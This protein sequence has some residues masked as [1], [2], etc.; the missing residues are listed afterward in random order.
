F[1]PNQSFFIAFQ[2]VF[3]TICILSGENVR[4]HELYS[5]LKKLGVSLND[6]EFQELLQKANVAEDGTVNFNS[7]MFALGKTRLFSE[8]TMLKDAIQAID[9]IEGDQVVVHELPSFMRSMGVRLTDQEFQQA[10]KQIPVDGNGKVFVRDFIEVLTRTL[11]FTELS[12]L[13][14]T[15]KG[16]S[17]I[18]G[19]KVAL[20]NLK[21]TLKNMGICFYPQ[22][23]EELIQTT[24]TDGE[25]NIDI[26]QIV[27]KISKTQR[28]IEI[29]VLNNAIKTFSQFKD[30]QVS[31]SDMQTC[32]R[33]IGVHLTESELEESIMS[34]K[35]SSDGMVDVKE[36][37]SAVKGTGRFQNY[38]AV[39]EVIS[40]LK[41]LKEHT[42]MDSTWGRRRSLNTFRFKLANE[43]IS[44]VLKAAHMTEAGW[45]KFN[46]F[47]RILTRNP[48]FKTSA[49][50]ANGFNV[51]DKLNNGRIGV[52]ELHMIMKSFSINLPSEDLSEALAYCNI[53]DNETV[54]LN[55]FLRGVA[56]TDTFIINPG[57]QLTCMALSKCKDNHLDLQALESTLN[58]MDLPKA[59]ELLQDVMKMAQ[60]DNNGT[61]DFAEFMRIFIVVS[62]LPEATVLKD[63][64]DAMSNI[65]DHQVHVDELPQTLASAGLN[66]T[67]EELQSLSKSLTAAGDGTVGFEDVMI[68]MTGAQSFAEFTALQNAFRVI[69]KAFAEK[70]KKED[71]PGVLE[72]LGIQ[73]SPDELQAV[74]ASASSDGELDGIEVVKILSNVPCISES[75]ALQDATKVVES[76]TD[77][78][79][80]VQELKNTLS[81]VGVHLPNTT[82]NELV[83][84]TT[85]DKNGRIDFKDFLLALGETDDFTELEALQ[86]AITITGAMHGSQQQMHEVQDVL[87][88]LG[89][90]L[91]NE[92]FQQIVDT[93]D[94][95][96][97]GTIKLE[98]F[99][100]ALSKTQR[101]RDSLALHS[102]VETFDRLKD[103]KVDTGELETIV[104][105]LGINLSNLEFQKAL[106][107]TYVDEDRKANFK[108]FLVNVMDNERFC[109][110]SAIYGLYSLVT[111]MNNDKVDISHLKDVLAAIGITLNKEEMK[112]VMKNIMVDDNGKVPLKEFMRLL[113]LTQRFSTAVEMD[114]ALKAMQSIKQDKVN[115]EDLD[116]I[117]RMMGLHLSLNEIQ[118][119][120]KYV[121]QN[122]DGTVSLRDFMFGFTKTQRFSKAKSDR[123]DMVAI[124]DVA[125]HLSNMG[126]CLTQEQLQEA[127]RHVDVDE[128][129]KV[130]MTELL[131]SAIKTWR[132]SQAVID[133][134][135]IHNLDGVLA[136]MGIYL[137]DD[138]V[139][140][141]LKYAAKDEDGRVNLNDFMKGVKSIQLI[142]GAEGQMIDAGDLSSTLV[143]MGINLTEDEMQEALEHVTLDADGKVNLKDVLQSV[144]LMQRPSKHERD[145][146]STQNLDSILTSTGI[147]LT[148]DKLQEALKNTPLDAEGK[149]NLG[150]FMKWVR[151][152]QLHPQSSDEKIELDNLKEEIT[153]EKAPPIMVD[154]WTREKKI[155]ID[156]LDEVLDEMGISLTNKQLY[157]ALK[158][159]PM[160]ADGKVDLEAFKRGASAVLTSERTE[161][162]T[163]NLK[164]FMWAV[165]DLSSIQDKQVD[166]KNLESILGGMGIYLTQEEL[167]DALKST[168]CNEDG[169]VNLKDFMKSCNA[170][171]TP[172]S[173][174][175]G[176]QP[177]K[178]SD[179]K[180]LK[181][182]K[183]TE[184]HRPLIPGRIFSYG[185]P[186]G[187]VFKAVKD[188]SKPQ[189]EAFRHAYDTF[190]KDLEGNIDL[191]ALETTAQNLGINLTEEEAFD[192]LIY[193]DTDGD[194]KV[195]FTDFLNII[196]DSNRFIQAV[197]PKNDDTETV[198]ARGILFFELLSK[199][200]ETCMLPRKTTVNIVSYYRQKFLE[201][202]CKKAW[203]ADSIDEDKEKGRGGKKKHVPKA[204]STPLSSFAGAARICIMN[205]KELEDYVEHLRFRATMAP[206]DSPYA[207]VPIFPL[208][209][210][211][212]GLVKGR[213]KADL[214]KLE[215]QRRMEPISSF[216][217]QFFHKKRWLQREPK[218]SKNP[219][220][221][222]ILT[223]GL[224]H[225]SRRLTMDNLD[226]IRREVKRTTDAYRKAIALRE[227]NKTLKL[228]RRLRGGEI[229][230]ESGNP[231]FYQTFS[232]YSWSWNVCQELVTPRELREYDKKLYH[233]HVSRTPTFVDKHI[234]ASGREKGN[235]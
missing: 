32:L 105:N 119:T 89:I 222:L 113:L 1:A 10:L 192:E 137:T 188:L 138:E 164:D 107:N 193:A 125:S 145:R 35:V 142:A 59:K 58:T 202:T 33:N 49:A 131:G 62:E 69:N 61:V 234:R 199:L 162:G 16:L 112:D 50:L 205:D 181:F 104:S 25:G 27:R 151:T 170:T 45:A 38:S 178:M 80:T 60:V 189:L 8:L 20:Q 86:H 120:L 111:R 9:K 2:D 73:L 227:R 173:T 7:F 139:Q 21:S 81:R 129:G 22:E 197:A 28:F 101:F 47:L 186:S 64:F 53:D 46:N 54:K 52:D 11:H 179:I 19:N 41:F 97:D 126:I 217:D 229:G 85:A 83:K 26:D 109:E 91:T 37:T 149:V 175:V 75:K 72:G 200:V 55:D 158:Y 201:S 226:E 82:F 177:S 15:I 99:L 171:L 216:E 14:D 153:V 39:L 169:T 79:M 210:N 128:N 51:L 221:T 146:V 95:D 96:S 154:G 123:G 203:R 133:W 233:R 208:I 92:E 136:N 183:V 84:S 4:D 17:D 44:Q 182:P 163:V 228:W 108:E 143:K 206:S 70:I 24:P 224:T 102:A 161:N 218:L 56:H 159:A 115:I 194:G 235:E 122:V 65:K 12:V 31:V 74:L 204:R 167:Q 172:S 140:Q 76:L 23:Y 166:I 174:E 116:S 90:H 191:P 185:T 66:L 150:E 141:A 42:K 103:E 127:L 40:A 121:V 94:A 3:G 135:K 67:P 87:G 196:T 144:M 71:L 190:S 36:L 118:Q 98:E 212:D 152:I 168:K 207:Q 214:Q 88:N 124:A 148:E 78:K 93:I 213:P 147:H 117:M 48:K 184:K 160:D 198:D 180:T 195:N 225:K 223:P 114:R 5:T 165:Q 18:Q 43:V 6:K 155:D 130:S 13:K 230:L 156:H 220:P 77:E 106:K 157:E 219:K 211:R 57:L 30:E 34:L 232:T 63:T 110:S 215:V 209:P 176:R 187:N 134:V 68:N 132:P 100:M 29:E 231:S